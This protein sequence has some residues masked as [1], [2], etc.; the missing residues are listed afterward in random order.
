M[1]DPVRARGQANGIVNLTE[2]EYALAMSKS[3]S[4]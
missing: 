1:S 3:P 2:T 4:S